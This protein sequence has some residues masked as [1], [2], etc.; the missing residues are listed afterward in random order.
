MTERRWSPRITDDSN[1]F[2]AWKEKNDERQFGTH[3]GNSSDYLSHSHKKKEKNNLKV[4]RSFCVWVVVVIL[5]LL[6]LICPK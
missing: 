4:F 5:L 6:L 2:A 3:K 1:E